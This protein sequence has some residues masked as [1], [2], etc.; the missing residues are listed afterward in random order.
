MVEISIWGP[1]EGRSVHS[2]TACEPSTIL[3]DEE[4][5]KQDPQF[6]RFWA[7]D[8]SIKDISR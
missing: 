2:D 1:Y 4:K 8:V 7:I 6:G 3:L 5:F